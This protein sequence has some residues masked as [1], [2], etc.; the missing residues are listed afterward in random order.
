MKSFLLWNKVR[1]TSQKWNV[2]HDG[3][4]S[5]FSRLPNLSLIISAAVDSVFF[6]IFNLVNAAFFFSFKAFFNFLNNSSLSFFGRLFLC[7]IP[8]NCRY[9]YSDKNRDDNKCGNCC[10]NYCNNKCRIVCRW[11][12]MA[13][14][15]VEFS[16]TIFTIVFIDKSVNLTCL[17]LTV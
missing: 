16:C 13:V 8:D 7:V 6:H 12:G 10:K 15:F 3:Y 4:Y 9:K 2:C 1:H 17:F 11:S 5:A 14:K